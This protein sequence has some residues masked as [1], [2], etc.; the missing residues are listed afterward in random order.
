MW[1][2]RRGVYLLLPLWQRRRGCIYFCHCGREGGGVP[3]FATA[4]EKEGRLDLELQLISNG[5]HP[6]LQGLLVKDH[7]TMDGTCWPAH[8]VH[9]PFIKKQKSIHTRMK[10]WQPQGHEKLKLHKV[11]AATGT[12]STDNCRHTALGHRILTTAHTKHWQLQGHTD[13]KP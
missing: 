5:L 3:T 4:I 9:I 10:H 2:R 11:L 6:V 13:I 12:W 7:H 1:Q 8:T